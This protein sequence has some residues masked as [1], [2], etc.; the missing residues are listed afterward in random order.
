M[1]DVQTS[2]VGAKLAP[3]NVHKWDFGVAIDLRR[4]NNLHWGHFCENQKYKHSG[5]MEPTIH[6]LFY[7]DN[8]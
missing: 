7:A 1:A 8:F 5:R 2:V 6:I 4:L 3:A